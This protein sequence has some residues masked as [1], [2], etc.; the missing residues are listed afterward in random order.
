MRFLSVLL[1]A[2]AP[3]ALA[4]VVQNHSGQKKGLPILQHDLSSFGKSS[5]AH[6]EVV[7]I[8]VNHGGGATPVY[9]NEQIPPPPPVKG[10]APVAP[11]TH[12][13]SFFVLRNS[14]YGRGTRGGEGGVA[15]VKNENANSAYRLQL[16]VP[17]DS[18]SVL[19]PSRQELE[20]RSSSTSWLRTT[21]LLSLLSKL[22]AALLPAGWTLVFNPTPT[23]PSI[24]LL[25][26]LCKLWS[27]LLSVSYLDIIDESCSSLK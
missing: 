14:A 13:V 23:I 9:L 1:S 25:K 3:V 19:T 15:V 16:V 18:F 8:W 7:V 5:A 26:L 4:N 24:L 27:I 6:T 20:T 12:E 22:P 17:R 10:N 2:L 11:A 21:L